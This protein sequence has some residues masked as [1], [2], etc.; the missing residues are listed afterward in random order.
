MVVVV[1]QSD[2]SNIREGGLDNNRRLEGSQEGGKC[3]N[4]HSQNRIAKL[5]G[6]IWAIYKRHLQTKKHHRQ[7]LEMDDRMLKDIGLGRGDVYRIVNGYRA[8]SVVR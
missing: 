8:R 4:I 5:L 6:A 2:K 1:K 7:L 3:E